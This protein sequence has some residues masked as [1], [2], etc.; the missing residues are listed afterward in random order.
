MAECSLS[1]RWCGRAGRRGLRN[2]V[3]AARTSSS[4]RSLLRAIAAAE[5]SPA[6]VITWA[7]GLTAL[8]AAHTP[9]TERATT[10]IDDGQPAASVRAPRPRRRSLFAAYAG[11][12]KTAARRR[13]GR[14]PARRRSARR[15]STTIRATRALDDPIARAMSCSR[16]ASVTSVVWAK[17][18]TS[19]LHCRTSS[20][21]STARG[22]RRGRRAAGRAPRGRGSTGSAARRGPSARR[23]PGTSTTWSRSPVATSSRRATT[24]GPPASTTL[25]VPTVRGRRR[26]SRCRRRTR[27]R[28]RRPRRDRGAAARRAAARRGTGSPACARPGRCAAGRRR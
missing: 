2:A 17:K 4:V 22:C 12:T 8:P 1:H 14:R 9:G 15:R 16:S 7:R 18:T 25:E 21:C 5:P 11:R 13:R 10:G 24:F 27:R 26:R 3:T 19:W 23:T 28:S 6:A 20:A